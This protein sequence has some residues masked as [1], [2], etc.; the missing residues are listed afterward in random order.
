MT[1]SITKD[2]FLEKK[3]S[4]R[5][6]ILRIIIYSSIAFL[7]P[8]FFGN[9]QYLSGTIVNCILILAAMNIKKYELIP[10]IVLPSIAMLIG[11]FVFYTLFSYFL[12]LMP[13]IWLAN[14]SL[15][16]LFKWLKSNK[17]LNF[18]SSLVL[19]AIAKTVILFLAANFLYRMDM[20]AKS[21][22]AIFGSMQLITALSGGVLALIAQKIKKAFIF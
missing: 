9:M 19:S 1:K 20:A 11:G 21:I 6:N 3:I 2:S 18:I 10:V 4:K 16:F 15:V 22:V 14:A 12:Y 13:V 5:Q 17:N 8:L 7:T